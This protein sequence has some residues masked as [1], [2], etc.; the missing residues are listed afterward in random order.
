MGPKRR[1]SS[2]SWVSDVVNAASIQRVWV[3]SLQHGYP[4]KNLSGMKF[5]KMKRDTFD[6]CSHVVHIKLLSHLSHLFFV[7]PASPRR[8]DLLDTSWIPSDVLPKYSSHGGHGPKSS[9]WRG[10]NRG[11][12]L[13]MGGVLSLTYTPFWEG[14]TDDYETETQPLTK[15]NLLENFRVNFRVKDECPDLSPCHPHV[16]IIMST[17]FWAKAVRVWEQ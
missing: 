12:T 9:P 1:D 11:R 15:G 6:Y 14:V 17:T 5:R 13:K 8:V 16:S 10:T 3:V 7:I 4:K 2:D